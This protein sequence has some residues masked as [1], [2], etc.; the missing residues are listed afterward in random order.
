MTNKKEVAQAIWDT[1]IGGYSKALMTPVEQFDTSI[2][3]DSRKIIADVLR[4]L[5]FELQYYQCC[6]DE[7][8]ED[9]VLDARDILDV[10]DEL[11]NL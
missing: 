2:T 9:M 3:S 4:E 7:G 6:G 1:Y 8:V 5:V 11:E 10:C